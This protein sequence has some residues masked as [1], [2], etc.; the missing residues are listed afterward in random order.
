VVGIN[1]VAMLAA[2]KHADLDLLRRWIE[3]CA[4]TRH[5]IRKEK[6]EQNETK[7]AVQRKKTSERNEYKTEDTQ[8]A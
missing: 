5:R 8:Q 4:T 1:K 7:K 3:L 6:L 2:A